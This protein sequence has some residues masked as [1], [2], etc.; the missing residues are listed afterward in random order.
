MTPLNGAPFRAMVGLEQVIDPVAVMEG[1]V[2]VVL[3][4][5]AMVIVEEHIEIVLVTTTVYCPPVFTEAV[6]VVAPEVTPGP[7]QL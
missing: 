5:T 7:L 6:A 2:G 1:V 4:G 3:D